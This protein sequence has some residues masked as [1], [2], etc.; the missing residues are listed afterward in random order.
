MSEEV[1]NYEMVNHPAHYN[2]YDVEVIDMIKRIWGIDAAILWCEITAFKYRMRMGTK[3]GNS[4]EQDLTKEKWYLNKKD[5]LT[6]ELDINT[7]EWTETSYILDVSKNNKEV[8][9]KTTN[10]IVGDKVEAPLFSTPTTQ[11]YITVN[12]EN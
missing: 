11:E 9:K 1:K 8:E 3:P 4:I 5:E 6:K 12:K 2:N 7:D 10:P